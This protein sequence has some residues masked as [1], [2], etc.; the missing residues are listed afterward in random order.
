M[1]RHYLLQDKQRGR[2][3]INL[4]AENGTRHGKTGDQLRAVHGLENIN[5]RGQDDKQGERGI[6][7][8]SQDLG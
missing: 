4:L 8:Q 3:D 1:K 7:V 6:N 2:G 5:E